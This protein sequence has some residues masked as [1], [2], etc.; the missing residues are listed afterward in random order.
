MGKVRNLSDD[1]FFSVNVRSPILSVSAYSKPPLFPYP[2]RTC[3]Q[4]WMKNLNEPGPWELRCWWRNS[5]Q[6]GDRIP[7]GTNTPALWL[8]GDALICISILC[9]FR[10][11]NDREAQRKAKGKCKQK[12]LGAWGWA[13]SFI[14]QGTWEGS[15]WYGTLPSWSWAWA[16]SDNRLWGVSELLG[17]SS[18]HYLSHIP[19]LL[20][21]SFPHGPGSDC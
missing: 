6:S 7:K 18:S 2:A 8:A 1:F 9:D 15:S 12:I 13:K 20:P 16:C 4:W 3:E 19:S 17:E 21:L 5:P 14:A 11:S 10:L